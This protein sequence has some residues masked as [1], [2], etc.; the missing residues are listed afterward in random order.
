VDY[1]FLVPNDMRPVV[2]ITSCV[3]VAVVRVIQESH[4]SLSQWMTMLCECLEEIA[5]NL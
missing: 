4:N 5:F 1:L 2:L 3:V